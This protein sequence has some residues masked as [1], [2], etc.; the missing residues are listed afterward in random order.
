MAAATKRMT[1][2]EIIN[3]LAE[4]SG[5]KKADAKEFFTLWRLWPRAK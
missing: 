5:M 2:T 1:Q 4:K 3:H